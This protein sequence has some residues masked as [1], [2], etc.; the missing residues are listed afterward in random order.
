MSQYKNRALYFTRAP[1]LVH[2][3]VRCYSFGHRMCEDTESFGR[4]MMCACC[5]LQVKRVIVTATRVLLGFSNLYQ[6][7]ECLGRR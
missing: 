7:F 4:S 3:F 6:T 5:W 1:C 2:L